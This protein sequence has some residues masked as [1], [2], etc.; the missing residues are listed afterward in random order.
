M[1]FFT[2]VH[3]QATDAKLG[4][5]P[6]TTVSRYTLTSRLSRSGTWGADLVATEARIN[7][8]DATPADRV[9]DTKRVVRCHGVRGGGTVELG[10][11][12]IDDLSID[13]AEYGMDIGGNTL[14]ILLGNPSVHSLALGTAGSPI[15]VK[16]A[17]ED[18]AAFTSGL[19]LT[20]DTTTYLSTGDTANSNADITNV[21]NV[22]NF[23]PG[24]PVYGAGIPAD[25]FV[26]LVTG[27][28]VTIS[29]DAT[30]TA[31]GVTLHTNKVFKEFSGESV[32]AALND[33]ATLVNENWREEDGTIVWLYRTREQA[34]DGDGNTLR[35]VSSADPIAVL[36]NNAAV[37]I[38]RLQYSRQ[39]AH[40]YNRIFPFGA[41]NG[42]ARETIAGVMTGLPPDYQYGNVVVG[43]DT[44]HYIEHIDSVAENG[45]IERHV[46]YRDITAPSAIAAAALIDLQRNVEPLDT[47]RVTL[48]KVAAA[49]KPGQTLHVEYHDSIDGYRPIDLN[50]PLFVLEAQLEIDVDDTHTVGVLLSNQRR[51]PV[52]TRTVLAQ[53]AAQTE[54][55]SAYNQPASHALSA[56][57]IATNADAVINNL[58][59]NGVLDHDGT[60]VG[61]Y[62]VTPVVRATTAG[63]TA[64]FAANTSGIADNTA[65]FDGYT[66]GQVVK[67]LRD[68]GLLT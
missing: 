56:E 59:I 34:T 25:T 60:T 12:I 36:S 43:A 20:F 24:D 42:S 45:P 40:V 14:S 6:I 51:W 52:T 10:A 55:G 33:L 4:G 38:T 22:T 48:E 67:A 16:D 39:S 66:I 3:D 13:A 11:G 18:I 9:L 7:H 29:N 50:G 65:T 61:L 19:G 17:V 30:A 63:G 62:N 35:A 1:A 41:G 32:L 8:T 27:T 15:T 44:F 23:T 68:I 2:D 58:E 53:L 47:Y 37:L 5:G 49:I 54:A 57:S 28:T 46:S 21:T 64:T 31:T 26:T